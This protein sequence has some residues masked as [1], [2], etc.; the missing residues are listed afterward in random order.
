MLF[1]SG[2]FAVPEKILNRS[3]FTKRSLQVR[4]EAADFKQRPTLTARYTRQF[5]LDSCDAKTLRFRGLAHLL[6]R[7]LELA[8]IPVARNCFANEGVFVLK[9]DS[10]S[11]RQRRA[12][13]KSKHRPTRTPPNRHPPARLL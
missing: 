3:S 4:Q 5:V 2:R 6:G 1:A 9:P 7:A 8:K 12:W 11:A 10:G 13:G